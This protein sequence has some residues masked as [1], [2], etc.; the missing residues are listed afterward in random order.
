MGH[1]EGRTYNGI[2]RHWLLVVAVELSEIA[3]DLSAFGF[4]FIGEDEFG[5][6]FALD[7]GEKKPYQQITLTLHDKQTVFVNKKI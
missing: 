3:V 2:M 6:E 1:F 7:D 4:D 5:E